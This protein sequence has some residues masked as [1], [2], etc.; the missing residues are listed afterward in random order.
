MTR[1]DEI[2]T[3]LVGAM[4]P[5]NIAGARWALAWLLR[6]FARRVPAETESQRARKRNLGRELADAIVPL[7]VS[8]RSVIGFFRA[9]CSRWDVDPTGAGEGGPLEAWTPKGRIRWDRALSRVSIAHARMVVHENPQFIAQFAV[10]YNDGSP[11]AMDADEA[12]LQ[13]FASETREPTRPTEYTETGSR[14]IVPRG[15]RT[16]LTSTNEAHHGADEKHGNVSLFRRKRTFDRVTGEYVLHPF[17]S[18]NAVRGMWRDIVMDRLLSLVDLTTKDLSPGVSQS[19][20]A[21]GTIR[22]GADTAKVNNTLRRSLRELLPAWDLFAGTMAEQMMGGRLSVCDMIPVCRETAWLV[23][24]VVAPGADMIAFRESLPEAQELTTLRLLTRMT[25]REFGDD[26]GVQ[27][28]VNTEL[29]VPGTQWVHRITLRGIDG[30]RSV[31]ASCMADLLEEWSAT[32][33]VV[34]AGCAR[35]YG[36]TSFA[37]YQR[38]GD[39]APLP[40]AGEYIEHCKRH[41]DEIRELLLGLGTKGGESEEPGEP[42]RKP[43]GKAASKALKEQLAKRGAPEPDPSAADVQGQLL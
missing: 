3:H 21:G 29:V 43:L 9:L 16:V 28:L 25:H 26:E 36:Y 42:K 34:G 35:G 13:A 27:M 15:Y 41:A 40:D 6:G 5:N 8:E 18:G 7:A 37:P 17:I 31:V 24:D 4:I 19:L 38:E 2:P 30:V 11:E 39:C 33:G 32:G 1:P 23:R 20:F 12:L 22:S 10:S 14:T